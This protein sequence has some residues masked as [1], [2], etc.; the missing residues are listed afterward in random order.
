MKLEDFLDNQKH[1]VQLELEPQG[2]LLAEVWHRCP[3]KHKRTQKARNSIAWVLYLEIKCGVCC[4]AFVLTRWP[5]STRSSSASLASRDRRR[6]SQ[7]SKVMEQ[8]QK[9]KH[10]TLFILEDCVWKEP[11]GIMMKVV[12]WREETNTEGKHNF[13]IYLV[14]H[15]VVNNEYFPVLSPKR[16]MGLSYSCRA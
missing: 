2:L 12:W 10:S 11:T 7:S 16:M 5:S 3:S 14:H 9:Y 15:L 6:S 13:F 8:S 4:V 1:R